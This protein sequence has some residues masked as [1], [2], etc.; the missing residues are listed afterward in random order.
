MHVEV[1]DHPA[2]HELLF[3][4]IASEAYALLLVHLARNRE[5][6]LTRQLRV[7]ALLSCLHLV[8]QRRAIRQPLRCVLRQ[9]HLGVDDASLVGEVVARPSRAS[10][11]SDAER[12]AAD[13]TALEPFA[14]LMTLALK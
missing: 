5:L 8:P 3:H 9:Q 11:S 2:L 7:L 1:G 6:H 14:R 4:E 12:Y 10:C 13:A